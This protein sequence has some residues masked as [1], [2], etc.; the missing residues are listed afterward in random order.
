MVSPATSA[1][2][3]PPASL[4]EKLKEKAGEVKRKIM[5]K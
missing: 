5:G 4:S 1:K 2:Q 3:A